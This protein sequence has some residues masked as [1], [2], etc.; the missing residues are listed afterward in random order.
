MTGS[1]KRPS[2][3]CVDCHRSAFD[4]L[5]PNEAGNCNP[6]DTELARHRNR[7]VQRSRNWKSTLLFLEN[8]EVRLV[9]TTGPRLNL[10]EFHAGNKI[11]AGVTASA[12]GILPEVNGVSDP[13][14]YGPADLQT[15][16]GIGDIQFGSVIGDGSGQT[17]AIVDAYDDPDFVDSSD[18]TDYPGSDLGQFDSAL[19]VPEPSS[20]SFTKVNQEG[21]ESPLPGEDPAGAGNVN[22]NWEIEEALDIEYAHGLAPGA[23][24]VLV[25]ATTDSNA[26]LFAAVQE[27]ASLPGVSVVSMSWGLDEYSGEQTL[28][29]TFV[30]PTNNAG[31]TFVA[32]SG[33]DG[34]YSV[35][36]NGNPTTTPGVLYPAASPDVLGVGGTTLNLN[37]DSSYNSET[38]WSG[39]GGG[40]SLYETEPPYQ[41][42][43]QSTD[44]RTVPDV[45]FDADPN[46]G[47][48]VYDSYNNTDNSGPW[49]QVGGTSLAAPSWAAVLA[50]ANQGRVLAG[51]SPLSGPTSTS[52]G[53]TLSALYAISSTDFNDITSGSN[54]VFSAGPGY[55]EVTGLGSPKANLLVADLATYGTASQLAVTS[56]PPSSVITG[57]SFG[58]VVAAESPDGEVDPAYSGTVTI[59]L[60]SNPGDASLA[61][62]LTATAY[63][64][65]AVFDGLSVNE[66]GDGYTLQLASSSFAAIT[67]SQFDVISNSTPWQETFYPVPT[68]ASLRA[69]IS[70]ADSNAYAYNTIELSAAS[71]LLS[72]TTDGELLIDN[73]SSLSGKALTITGQG[74]ANTIISSVFNWQSRIF[75]IDGAAGKSLSVLFDDLAVEGGNAQNGGNLGVDVALVCDAFQCSRRKEQSAGGLRIRRDGRGT[76]PTRRQRGRGSERSGGRDLPGRRQS[77]AGR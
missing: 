32:A 5:R 2:K 52:P 36:D 58:V 7:R 47:V 66:F 42:G 49:V 34:G 25:E 4:Q 26:N 65:V 59:A 18:T 41:E 21:S 70:Q 19:G 17:I 11:P 20:F 23:K 35:D 71:Y 8:L 54:G 77:L 76:R 69:A 14:G 38:A 74:S 50:I 45:G 22:G 61:G 10:W 13:V 73:S 67:T 56:Q 60:E 24:I 40:T 62:T 31:V 72:N 29:S 57:D 3:A 48:G 6:G 43:T 1:R 28:D 51:G 27:A 46:T 39:S 15:A 9:M 64:G 16:Y 55:D 63:H 30:A 33:D 37:A 53:Q 44:Y 68:D 75:E 12:I